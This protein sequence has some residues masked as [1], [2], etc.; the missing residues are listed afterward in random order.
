MHPLSIL[1]NKFKSSIS[2]QEIF[3]NI[4][5]L[6]FEKIFRMGLSIIVSAMV[7]RY[8]GPEKFGMMN[9]A[10][11][12]VGLFQALNTLGLDSV[13]VRNLVANKSNAG[14][15]LGST[16]FLRLLGTIVMILTSTILISLLRPNESLIYTLISIILVKYIFLSFE[17]IDLYFQSIVQSKYTVYSRTISF[18][19]VSGLKIVLVLTQQTLTAITAMV[20]LDSAIA[21]VSLVLFYSKKSD[22]KIYEWKIDKHIIKELFRDAWPLLLSSVAISLHAHID[23]IMLGVMLSDKDVGLYSAAT[24]I[25]QPLSFIGL[26]IANSVFPAL[27]KTKEN[28]FELYL[29]RFQYLFSLLIWIGIFLGVIFSIFSKPIV[30]LIFGANYVISAQILAIIVWNRSFNFLGIASSKYFIIE[31]LTILQMIRT[32]IGGLS[33]IALNTLLIPEYGSQGAAW[34]TLIS[35]SI[36]GCFSVLLF[37]KTRFLFVMYLK[38]LNPIHFLKK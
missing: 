32:I 30:S 2:F 6:T 10:I 4:G 8:L 35:I 38:S 15:Y 37:K 24:T 36:Q 29:K 26:I 13:V 7:A 1:K 16:L 3:K 9:Y 33:N 20:T 12:F 5:W 31:N 25:S 34:A 18:I 22:L 27:V 17:T 14:K 21:A 11:S 19:T 23:K 28:N